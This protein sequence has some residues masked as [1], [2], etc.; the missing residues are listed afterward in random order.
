MDHNQFSYLT[1]FT[2]VGF[3]NSVCGVFDHNV[4]A[5]TN[6]DFLALDNNGLGGYGTGNSQGWGDVS[7]A[8]PVGWG[9]TNQFIYIEDNSFFW[10][11][12][13]GTT[14]WA[15]C[16]SV[17][18][19]KWVFRHNNCTNCWLYTHGTD[20]GGRFRGFR[21]AEVYNNNF[22]VPASAGNVAMLYLRSG[23]A[24]ICSNTLSGNFGVLWGMQVDRVVQTFSAYGGANGLN[25]FDSNSTTLLASGTNYSANGSAVLIDTNNTWTVGQWMTNGFVVVDLSQNGTNYFDLTPRQY[26][27]TVVT[28]DAHTI[29]LSPAPN[30][31]NIAWTNG[32]KYAIYQVIHALDQPGS[33]ASDPVQ[34][35]S[36]GSGVPVNGL[37][38]TISAMHQSLDPVYQWNN[39]IN[40]SVTTLGQSLY[41][42]VIQGRDYFEGTPKS[43][44][45]PL[46]YPHPLVTTNSTGGGGGSTNTAMGFAYSFATNY[47]NATLTVSAPSVLNVNGVPWFPSFA[48]QDFTVAGNVVHLANAPTPI[49]TAS[50]SSALLGGTPTFVTNASSACV[51]S[52]QFIGT[53][54]DGAFNFTFMAGSAVPAGSNYFTFNLS[55]A[56]STNPVVVTFAPCAVGNFTNTGSGTLMI[57]C[58]MQVAC[59][60]NSFTLQTGVSSLT[61]SGQY[62]TAFHIDRP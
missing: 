32:D 5:W 39:T 28:N 17:A 42:T 30:W 47:P 54:R 36:W 24:V 58:R 52:A 50:A 62:T 35:T 34:D 45:T 1:G 22:Q 55:Q 41:G 48:I 26:F 13:S 16:D 49:T 53:P 37:T 60:S 10:N 27:G 21:A 59:T 38:M 33:G 11:T 40:G 61:A 25:P 15:I 57:A 14:T 3:Y 9:S 2:G 4:I 46:V 51:A 8:N 23:T 31:G 43:G 7:W 6:G 19:A 12:N 56:L 29:T 18:G 44:Y 20:S